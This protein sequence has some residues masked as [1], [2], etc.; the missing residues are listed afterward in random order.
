[1]LH[2]PATEKPDTN[3]ATSG[4]KAGGLLMC[5]ELAR[6][7]INYFSPTPTSFVW[8]CD[9]N[10]LIANLC[11]WLYE[12]HSKYQF[13]SFQAILCFEDRWSKNTYSRTQNF[14]VGTE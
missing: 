8:R 2:G 4:M 1:M 3:V 5:V 10:V 9:E 7:V 11:M 12:H 14:I 6:L 13:F